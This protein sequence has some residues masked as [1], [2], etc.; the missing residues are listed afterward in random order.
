MIIEKKQ[1]DAQPPI[2]FGSTLSAAF[3]DSIELTRLG[4]TFPLTST[5]TPGTRV[6]GDHDILQFEP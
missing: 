3:P 4:R 5:D 1:S 2:S 6:F